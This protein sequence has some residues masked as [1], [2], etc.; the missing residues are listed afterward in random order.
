MCL[1]RNQEKEVIFHQEDVVAN[2]PSLIVEES[3]ALDRISEE[4]QRDMS[5]HVSPSNIMDSIEDTDKTS[6]TPSNSENITAAKRQDFIRCKTFKSNDWGLVIGA[7][8]RGKSHMESGLGCQDFHLYE[9][10]GKGWY[11]LI[12]SDGASSAEYAERGSRGNCNVAS[13]LFKEMLSTNGWIDDSFFPSEL[14]WYIE[15]RSIFEKMKLIYRSKAKE[16]NDGTEESDF[17]ATIILCLITPMGL[18]VTHIGDGRMGYLSELDE[19]KSMMTPHKGEEANQTLFLQGPWTTPHV[20]ALRVSGVTVPEV[21]VIRGT[22][23]AI[24]LMSDGCERAAWECSI[25]NDLKGRYEDVNL[26]HP[27]FMNPLLESINVESEDRL[28]LLIDIMDRG[29]RACEQ[30]RD[31]KTMLIAIKKNSN[32]LSDIQ[33]GQAD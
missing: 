6:I 9:E 11:L 13:K 20:P 16:Q 1:Q 24:V 17:N 8:L 32:E 12:V 7:S 19:W 33:T 30:E 3:E 23:K 25:Y 15:C 27:A 2:N 31:D 18:L 5:I 10:L 4:D 22:P 29:T 26:P 21:K 28:Q 14:E